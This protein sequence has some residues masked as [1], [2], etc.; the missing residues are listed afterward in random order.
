MEFFL[1]Q[2]FIENEGKSLKAEYLYEQVW[3]ADMI[4][5]PNAVKN[6]VSRLR[7]KIRGSGHTIS[8]VYGEGYCFER[9]R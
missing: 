8:S 9:E 5:D 2:L 1:L 7:K 6:A 3:G 4:D